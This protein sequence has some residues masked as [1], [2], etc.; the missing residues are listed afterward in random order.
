[1][2]KIYADMLFVKWLDMSLFTPH[3]P[4]PLVLLNSFLI[5]ADPTHFPLYSLNEWIHFYF[6]GENRNNQ[7]S[8]IQ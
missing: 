4:F 2:V 5:A 8:T 1:M 7:K 3:A 6:Y